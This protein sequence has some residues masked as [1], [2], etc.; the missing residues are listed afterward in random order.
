VFESVSEVLAGI[1]DVFNNNAG[2]AVLGATLGAGL[3]G[4][5]IYVAERRKEKIAT[6][7]RLIE[8]YTSPSFLDIRADAGLALR[9]AMKAGPKSWDD[10][11]HNLDKTEWSKISKMDHFYQK[12]DLVVSVREAHNPYISRYFGRE[13]PHWYVQYFEPIIRESQKQTDAVY[14]FPNLLRLMAGEIATYRQKLI[15]YDPTRRTETQAQS[16]GSA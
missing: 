11:Y 1:V 8:E 5:V 7:L 13:F 10:L 9:T 14:F 2:A 16:A 15:V 3:S 6:S 12:L 4:L